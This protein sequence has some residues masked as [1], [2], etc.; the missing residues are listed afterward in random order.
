MATTD[1]RVD[2]YIEKA[3]PFARPIL[4]RLRA[5]VHQGCPDVVETIKWSSPSFEYRGP[6]CMMAA[7]KAHCTFGFWKHTLVATT[8]QTMAAMG[9]FGRITSLDDLPGA[10]TFVAYVR[11]AAALNEQG[12]KV[13][14]PLKHPKKAIAMPEELTAAFATRKHAR[15]RATF[16]TLSPSH[17]REY[18]EWIVEAKRPETRAKRI[19][20]TLEWLAEGKSRNWKY[21]RC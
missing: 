15:A 13:P 1:P 7:F 12:V 21:E 2:A 20:T 16:E 10:R 5:L 6:L 19:A 9:Q 17:R 11:K 14:R 4:A 18:L 8:D 3:A